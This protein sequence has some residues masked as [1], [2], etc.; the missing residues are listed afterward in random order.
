MLVIVAGQPGA[1]K[2]SA[3][4]RVRA[5]LGPGTV[6]IDADELREHHPAYG[7]LLITNDQT[8]ATL[9]HPQVQRW[10][11]MAKDHCIAHR[12]NV[13]LSA[14][15]GNPD[16]ARRTIYQFR[17]AGYQV[18]MVVVAVHEATSQLNVLSRYQKGHER[19]GGRHVPLN[20]QRQAYTGLLD[21]VDQ[22]D[23]GWLVDAVQVYQRP[24]RQRYWAQIYWNE[25]NQRGRWSQPPET[26]ASI[27]AARN[28][29][30]GAEEIKDFC[31]RAAALNTCLPQELHSDLLI[32]VRAAQKHVAISGA[33]LIAAGVDFA[34]RLAAERAGRDAPPTVRPTSGN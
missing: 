18:Y 22:I 13:V 5:N 7:Q 2:T 26:R 29:P 3:E 9:T 11:K 30:W 33:S 8:A 6:T 23:A 10:V 27:E 31:D 32:A 19:A 15:M 1:G 4:D 12:Y 25:R 21:T 34:G 24:D 20:E 17:E 14:T 28:R 16:S